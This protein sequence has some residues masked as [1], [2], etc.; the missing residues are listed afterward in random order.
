MTYYILID[1]SY[2]VFYRI[3]ALVNWWKLSH[4]ED[5]QVNL[6]LN[7]EFIEKFKTTFV[8]KLNEIPKKLKLTKEQQKDVV[9]IIG[10]DCPRKNIWRHK[11]IDGYK[12]TRTNYDAQENPTF[13]PKPFFQL[14]YD[15]ELFHMCKYPFHIVEHDYLEAD[16]CLALTTKQIVATETDDTI[17]IITSDTDYLQLIQPNVHLYNLKYKTVNTAKNSCGDSQLDLLCKIISG[18]KSDN[19]PPLLKKC[20]AKTLQKIIETPSL[21][22][23]KVEQ[24]DTLREHYLRNKTL[25]DFNEIPQ[26]LVEQFTTYFMRLNII[27]DHSIKMS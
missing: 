3:F 26:E 6:H 22:F 25:I 7:D 15:G 2:F 27:T 12:G 14:V 11:L 1:G 18:D 13:H 10:K 23:D 5:S 17:Y 21:F 9:Y 8:T 20:G 16:D 19:I 4:K 24:D